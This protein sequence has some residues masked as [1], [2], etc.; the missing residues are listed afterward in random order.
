MNGL[1][2]QTVAYADTDTGGV[3]YHARYVELAERS[4][5]QW[6]LDAEWGMVRLGE[7]YG[8]DLVVHRLRAEYDRPARLEDTLLARTE[9]LEA[10]AARCRWR[11]DI[12]RGGERLARIDVDTVAVAR[13]ATALTRLPEA[14]LQLFAARRAAPTVTP[15]L[16]PLPA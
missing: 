10:G 9:L 14:L 6:L 15:A 2:R 11:T 3:M 16:R 1:V 7:A 8:I 12:L 4:R 13:R 5:L